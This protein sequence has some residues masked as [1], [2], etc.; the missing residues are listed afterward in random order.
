LPSTNTDITANT[1]LAYQPDYYENSKVMQNIDN[2]NSS[3]LNTF[4]DKVTT[5]YNN[6]YVDTADSETLARIEKIFNLT[7]APQDNINYRRS[8]IY[9]RLRG[10]GTFT[11]AFL[12]NVAESFENSE[13]DI[14]ENNSN[15]T[16]TVKFVGQ[17]GIPPNLDDLKDVIEEL[18]PA[19]LAVDYVFMYLIWSEFDSYN[20]TW[21]KCD[22]LNL[23]WDEFTTY[24]Q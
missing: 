5:V 18:K 22:S 8:R 23:T 20:N 6:L 21:S 2:A 9:S 14:I 10:Q 7:V 4:N 1:L 12:Q 24:K 3:E 13:V 11:V 17:K 15:Y 19:H 16:F